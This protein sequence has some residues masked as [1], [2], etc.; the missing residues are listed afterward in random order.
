MNS[1]NKIII[2]KH[3]SNKNIKGNKDI[4]EN[5]D[6]TNN[7]DIKIIQNIKNIKNIQNIKNIKD[8]NDIKNNKITSQNPP[9]AQNNQNNSS[10]TI[11]RGL[12][13]KAILNE[14]QNKK[15]AQKLEENPNYIILNFNNDE[16]ILDIMRKSYNMKQT[17]L[18]SVIIPTYNRFHSLKKA[19][20]SVKNQSYKNVEIIVINDASTQ[21][22]YKTES[23]GDDVILINLEQNMKVLHNS[24]SAH[25]LTRNEGIKVAKGKWIAFLDDD[26]Y[27][28]P[29][30]LQIQ[31]Y[32][33]EKYDMKLCS[34]NYFKGY[35]TFDYNNMD[36]YYRALPLDMDA[37]NKN[38]K[39]SYILKDRKFIYTLLSTMVLR[40]DVLDEVG[41]F[42]N[43]PAEDWEYWRTIYSAGY[44]FLF[45]DIML[46]YYDLGHA[47]G[48]NYTQRGK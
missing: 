17:D 7:K 1:P 36:N 30:K 22:E 29:E 35:D 26:D 28:I 15:L 37:L 5:I 45:L 12:N 39:Y 25:G 18:I 32:Y 23:L 9:N 48:R 14:I 8:I 43:V 24:K 10:L 47:G 38:D 41:L 19:I 11:K 44:Q 42:T 31:M 6:F 27:W 20:E 40:R 2:K 4:K 21:E 16:S 13:K 34:T 33:L 3:I 46:I